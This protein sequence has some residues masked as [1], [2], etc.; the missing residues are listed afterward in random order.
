VTSLAVES[1]ALPSD[2]A[3]CVSDHRSDVLPIGRPEQESQFATLRVAHDGYMVRIE[4]RQDFSHSMAL[5]RGFR[6][7]PT[8][9]RGSGSTPK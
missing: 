3:W 8:S 5:S 7:L 2:R 9:L 4:L 1:G 6:G